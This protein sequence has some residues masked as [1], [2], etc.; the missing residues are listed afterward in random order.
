VGTTA[1]FHGDVV[2]LGGVGGG[3]GGG[4]V[5]VAGVEEEQGGDGPLDDGGV[6]RGDDRRVKLG[7]RLR[8]CPG[9]AAG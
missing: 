3:D 8:Y 6:R 7:A 2:V 5:E 4:L 1:D 9:C